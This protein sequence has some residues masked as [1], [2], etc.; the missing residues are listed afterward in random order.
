MAKMTQA[1]KDRLAARAAEK[2]GRNSIQGLS[3]FGW[4]AALDAVIDG[5]VA[6]P[7]G[8]MIG[9]RPDGTVLPNFGL[10]K[11]IQ[12]N[13]INENEEESRVAWVSIGR[14]RPWQVTDL[15]RVYGERYVTARKF[16]GV[17]VGVQPFDVPVFPAVAVFT[18]FAAIWPELVNL[19][20]DAPAVHRYRWAVMAE[21]SLIG[22]TA[23][24]FAKLDG[25][26]ARKFSPA[27]DR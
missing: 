24:A 14:V 25:R 9:P 21:R 16:A 20:N 27:G 23:K 13:G 6:L 7:I 17:S 10:F 22:Y 8:L 2:R 26:D 4:G 1:T 18:V 12:R 11:D 5:T 19:S 3:A 15:Q